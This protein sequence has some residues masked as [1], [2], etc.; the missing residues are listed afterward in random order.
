MLFHV[1]VQYSRADNPTERPTTLEQL[2]QYSSWMEQQTRF[3]VKVAAVYWGTSDPVAFG[4]LEAPDEAA[5][6]PFL[7][8]LPG[9]PALTIVPIEPLAVAVSDGVQKLLQAA[10]EERA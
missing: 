3:Q 9:K 1:T 2:I 7:G 5:L 10:R 8:L 6:R 4:L